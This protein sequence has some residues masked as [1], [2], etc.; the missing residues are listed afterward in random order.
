MGTCESWLVGTCE[1]RLLGPFVGWLVGTCEGWLELSLGEA[2]GASLFSVS[3]GSSAVG[4]RLRLGA[5]LGLPDGVT[6]G[7]RLRL[8][9]ADGLCD[10]DI[11][12]RG[13]RLRLGAVVLSL[14][15][16][17]LALGCW[18]KLGSAEGLLDG[19]KLVLGA[20]DGTFEGDG[21]RL[22]SSCG[23]SRKMK[24][25]AVQLPPSSF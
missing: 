11:V 5:A 16:A 17:T 18:L 2:D 19:D 9:S 3:T 7:C 24:Q 25:T 22:V 20:D 1:G 13:G 6:L 14:D 12:V 4:C 23:P 21:L 10:G 15:G 8:G